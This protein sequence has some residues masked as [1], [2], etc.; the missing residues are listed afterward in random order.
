MSLS[1]Q[2]SRGELENAMD[3][4]RQLLA[5]LEQIDDVFAYERGSLSKQA[6]L[7]VVRAAINMA[8]AEGVPSSFGD[9]A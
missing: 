2:V 1:Y 3:L 9:A 7:S 4:N 5:A 8:L 6:A